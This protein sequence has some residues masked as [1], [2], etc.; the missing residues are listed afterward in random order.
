MSPWSEVSLM[1][2]VYNSKE[3]PEESQ[4]MLNAGINANWNLDAV[5]GGG[6]LGSH[7]YLAHKTGVYHLDGMNRN[8][9][10]II[11][12]GHFGL[13]WNRI[14]AALTSA[15]WGNAVYFFKGNQY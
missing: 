12:L 10:E 2:S 13:K 8:A 1:H 9:D 4:V 15:K 14:D 11:T 7:Y 6:P 5:W 3:G